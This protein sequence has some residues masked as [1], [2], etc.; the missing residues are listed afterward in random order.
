MSQLQTIN[1]RDIMNSTMD[2]MT[3]VAM[4]SY[5]L[6]RAEAVL[7]QIF[8]TCLLLIIAGVGLAVLKLSDVV[9]N[10]LKKRKVDE[11]RALLRAIQIVASTAGA[12]KTTASQTTPKETNEPIIV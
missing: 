6:L 2:N 5:G 11:D 7:D 9:K 4:K 8:R 10:S 3:E 12:F 1:W